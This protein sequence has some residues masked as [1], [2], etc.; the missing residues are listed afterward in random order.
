MVALILAAGYATRLYPLTL[1]TPKP[2]LKIGGKTIL[3]FICDEIDTIQEITKTIIISND[4]FYQHFLLWK[5][6]RS[7]NVELVVLNDGSTAEEN[8]LGAIGDI[9]FAIQKEDIEEE[10]L[11]VAGDN[12]FTYK[13]LD[14]YNFYRNNEADCIVV[15]RMEDRNALRHVGV[16]IVDENSKVVEFEEKP[17]NPRSDLAVYASYI[18]RSETI[19]LFDKY[20]QEGNKLDAPGHFAAWLCKRETVLAYRFDGECYDVGTPEAY[21]QVCELYGNELTKTP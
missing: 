17:Q 20:I 5:E 13:L 8:R 9:V 6:S 15:K 2:L 14:F 3:D 16:A 10:C 11:I 19:A 18:Y 21:T 1:N 4:K 7:F 12:F